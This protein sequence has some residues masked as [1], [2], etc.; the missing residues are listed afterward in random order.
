MHVYYMV[1]LLEMSSFSTD[2][3][4][5]LIGVADL[6]SRAFDNGGIS[7]WVFVSVYC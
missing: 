1:I 4:T 5:G 2:P 7:C 3:V 6:A